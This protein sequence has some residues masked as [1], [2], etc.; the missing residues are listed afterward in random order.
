[1]V[2]SGIQLLASFSG[3]EGSVMD[4]SGVTVDVVID[5]VMERVPGVSKSKL[6]VDGVMLAVLKV[7]L[8]WAMV[9][10]VAA[11]AALV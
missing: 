6:K 7:K 10:A 4:S 11:A 5:G 8:E 9:K 3:V 2:L 1:M